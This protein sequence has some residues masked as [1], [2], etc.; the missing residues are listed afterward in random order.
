MA[1]SPA[2][3]RIFSSEPIPPW[4]RRGEQKRLPDLSGVGGTVIF[5]DING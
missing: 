5:T 3:T 1:H 2:V 4:A